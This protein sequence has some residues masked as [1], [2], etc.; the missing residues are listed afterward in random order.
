MMNVN[1]HC[2]D[3]DL[4][5]R[6]NRCSQFD[7]YECDWGIPIDGCNCRKCEGT[8]ENA[9]NERHHAEKQ[10]AVALKREKAKEVAKVKKEDLKKGIDGDL[11]SMTSKR[12]KEEVKKLRSEIRYHRDQKGDDR[13]WVDDLRLYEALPEGAAGLDSTLPPEDIFL[14]N[15]KKFCQSRQVPVGNIFKK[16]W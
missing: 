2:N 12:L 13:C 16:D 5:G 10:K 3:Y 6:C 11:E 7:C 4:E 8:R 15:C 9:I 1:I 14:A